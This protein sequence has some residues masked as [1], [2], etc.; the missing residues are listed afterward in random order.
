[1]TAEVDYL[2]RTNSIDFRIDATVYFLAATVN[3][4]LVLHEARP[5][6]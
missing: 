4:D 6:Y 3:D 5:V 2:I 1:M